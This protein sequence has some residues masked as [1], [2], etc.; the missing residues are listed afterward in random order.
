MKKVLNLVLSADFHPYTKMVQTAIETWDSIEVEGVETVYYFG[1]PI[2]P[3]TDKFIYLPVREGYETMSQKTFL[4]LEWAIQNKEF[5]YLARPHSSI[6]VNKKALLNYVQTLPKE[7]VFAGAKVVA[8]RSW[9][10]GGTGFIFSRDV[11]E[12]LV[13]NKHLLESGLMEDMAL[14]YVFN[15]FGIPYTDGCA[16]TID[17]LGDRWRCMQYGKGENFEFTEWGDIIKSEGHYYYRV[18][19]D[20]KRDVDEMIMKELFK[21]FQ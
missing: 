6:Y 12:K 5:D 3:N 19:Q 17:N 21:V 1:E 9:I 18:K 15:T 11:V 4:A 16:C 20:L 8:E 2:K 14:S 10:W 13:A 7:N